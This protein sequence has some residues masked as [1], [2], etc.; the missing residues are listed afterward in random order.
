MASS[1]ASASGAAPDIADLGKRIYD[2]CLPIQEESPRAVFHQ[3][4]IF[5]LE[6]LPPG[7]DGQNDIGLA[8]QV[9]Q[10][11]TDEKL[12]KVVHD[13]G[14]GWKVRTIEEAKK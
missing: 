4:D 3:Q 2:E 14:M 5:D 12:L 10:K 9:L 11:L 7:P 6:I 1:S 8:V 13:G